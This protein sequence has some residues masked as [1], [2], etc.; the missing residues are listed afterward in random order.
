M[1]LVGWIQN[2]NGLIRQYF[3]KGTNFRQVSDVLVAE[4]QKKLNRRPRKTHGF[5]TP[6]EEYTGRFL[7]H[8]PTP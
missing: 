5:R 3:P 2:T 7:R 1:G 8:V 6:D 4:V